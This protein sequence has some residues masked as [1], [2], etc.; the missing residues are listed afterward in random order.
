MALVRLPFADA[1]AR[2]AGRTDVVAAI[3]ASLESC[4]ISGV[5]EA[6]TRVC[7]EWAAAGVVVRRVNTDVAFHS[8]AMDALTADL[9]RNVARLPPSRSATVPLYS[10]ALADPRSTAPRDP[11]YW[12]ANL[13]GRVRFAESVAAAAD[14]GHRL[15]LEVSAHPVVSHSVIETLLGLGIDEHGAVP[16]LRRDA[17]EGGEVE[18]AA[19]AVGD[20]LDGHEE[21]LDLAP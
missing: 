12:V 10:T 8:P 11:A 5:P 9:A 17:P 13:R 21:L 18:R 14:D 4:V 20:G 7:D 15:F 1:D 16:V 2:L 19:L 3:S 6:V